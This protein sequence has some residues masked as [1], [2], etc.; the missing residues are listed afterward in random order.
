[1]LTSKTLSCFADICST[2]YFLLILFRY[3]NA[4]HFA[5]KNVKTTEYWSDLKVVFNFHQHLFACFTSTHITPWIPSF[6]YFSFLTAA[7]LTVCVHIA[8]FQLAHYYFC[9]GECVWTVDVGVGLLSVL[10][11]ITKLCS[12]L[13]V[14]LINAV[15]DVAKALGDLIRTTKAAAGKP[16]DDPAMLQLKSSAKVVHWC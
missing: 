4:C 6:I 16:H 2:N 8:V 9:V 5:F 14:V 13:Q 3:L 10:F 1:M 15:K 11:T 12:V 7:H